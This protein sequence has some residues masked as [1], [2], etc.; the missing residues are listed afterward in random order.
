MTVIEHLGRLFVRRFLFPAIAFLGASMVAS[1]L[2]S[3]VFFAIALRGEPDQTF[4]PFGL[5]GM[6]IVAITLGFYT[7]ALAGVP[8]C[9]L[10]WGIRLTGLRRGWADAIAGGLLGAVMMHVVLHGVSAITET[11]SLMVGV[12]GLAGLIGGAAYWNFTG[13]PRV[14]YI[15]KQN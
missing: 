8:A 1:L 4:S 12:F 15:A 2:V 7:A 11:P 6:L 10:I 5:F 9:L 14:P 13:R 3:I